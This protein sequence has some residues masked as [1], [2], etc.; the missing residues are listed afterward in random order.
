MEVLIASG[1]PLGGIWEEAFSLRGWKILKSADFKS[2]LGLLPKLPGAVIIAESLLP[3]ALSLKLIREKGRGISLL[4]ASRTQVPSRLVELLNAGAD[5]VISSDIPG[6]LLAAKLE[7]ALRRFKPPEAK[8]IKSK[9]GKIKINRL[10]R[11]ASLNEKVLDLTKTEFEL[12]AFILE[13]P[14][15]ALERRTLLQMIRSDSDSVQ[16]S[17]V[18]KHVESLRKKL[19]EW[20]SC[21]K[22]VHGIGYAWENGTVPFSSQ[23]RKR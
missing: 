23:G 5:D 9:D 4:V 13:R 6:E 12:L 16:S 11:E 20:G 19:G 14:G 7:A 15:F 21:I 2:A 17:T 3:D 18:D 22:T 8:E 10:K 1:E